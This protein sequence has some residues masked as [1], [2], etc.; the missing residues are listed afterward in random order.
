MPK[1]LP[2]EQASIDRL[3]TE[4]IKQQGHLIDG[5]RVAASNDALME[6]ISPI[7]GQVIT[8]RSQWH[9]Q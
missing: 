2:L 7:D 1:P 9:R 3:R 6:V 4:P 5:H 8:A